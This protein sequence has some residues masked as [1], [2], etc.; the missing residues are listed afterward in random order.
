MKLIEHLNWRYATKKFDLSKKVSKTDLDQLKEGVRLSASSYGLQPYK[1]LVVEDEQVM[2]QL[3]PASYGQDQITDASHLFIFCSFV[4]TDA[5]K[6]D[7][8]LQLKADAQEMNVDDLQGYGDFMKTSLSYKSENEMENWSAKQ[9][10]IGLGNLLIAAAELKIDACPMEGF[11]V[12]KYNDILDLK[13][14]GL[15]AAVVVPVGYR[16]VDDQSQFA[17]KVRKSEETLFK[18]I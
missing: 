18:T 6:I 12:E 2:K 13:R 16:S 11:E 3:K 9:A 7:E 10:Y 15:S 1:V 17:V 5:V 4:D 14:Q 8:Y